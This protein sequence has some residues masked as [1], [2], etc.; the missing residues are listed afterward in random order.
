MILRLVL[1]MQFP[2][3]PFWA[4]GPSFGPDVLYVDRETWQDFQK[5]ACRLHKAERYDA[6]VR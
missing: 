1:Q 2:P 5:W 6:P 3:L 4:A